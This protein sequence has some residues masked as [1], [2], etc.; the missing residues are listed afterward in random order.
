MDN[1]SA[2]IYVHLRDSNLYIT[3]F[4]SNN[5]ID[6]QSNTIDQA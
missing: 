3:K 5:K 2:I 6:K 1:F 4:E